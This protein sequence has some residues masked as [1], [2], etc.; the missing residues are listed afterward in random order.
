MA[1][2]R[3]RLGRDA[4]LEV[5]VG[6]DHEGVVV[7]DLVA[8]AV[9]ARGQHALGE[10]HADGVGDALAERA[11]RDLDA[12]RVAVLGVAGRRASRAGGSS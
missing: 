3:A 6:G 1:G 2:E 4:L 5:A 10:R 12:G 11:G 8:G 9:E 7:D